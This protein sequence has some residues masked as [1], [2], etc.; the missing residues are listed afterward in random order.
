MGM[1]NHIVNRSNVSATN[2]QHVFTIDHKTALK[3]AP[4]HILQK[5][6]EDRWVDGWEKNIGYIDH[7]GEKDRGDVG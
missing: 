6:A 3:D 1:N 5:L 2:D 7:N 4:P